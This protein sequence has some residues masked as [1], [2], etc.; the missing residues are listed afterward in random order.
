MLSYTVTSGH[1]SHWF[2]DDK[3][4][5]HSQ[6]DSPNSMIGRLPARPSPRDA[7]CIE[8]LLHKFAL[9]LW[10]GLNVE[11][12]IDQADLQDLLIVEFYEDSHASPVSQTLA[13]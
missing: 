9:L 7:L 10:P 5:R 1:C 11:P 6:A 2:F 3:S 4:L 12:G 8:Y 13:P